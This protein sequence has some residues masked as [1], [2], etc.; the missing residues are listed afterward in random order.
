[1][2][3]PLSNIGLLTWLAPLAALGLLVACG[4][5]SPSQTLPSDTAPA[6]AVLPAPVAAAP[7]GQVPVAAEAATRQDANIIKKPPAALISTGVPQPE[8]APS[9]IGAIPAATLVQPEP[10]VQ[11]VPPVESA[12][13]PLPLDAPRVEPAQEPAALTPIEIKPDPWPMPTSTLPAESTQ[14]LRPSTDTAASDPAQWPTSSTPVETRLPPSPAP[15]A[16][17]TQEPATSPPAAPSAVPSSM[18][19]N[20]QTESAPIDES[21]EQAPSFTLPTVGGGTTSLD[22]YLGQRNVVLVFYRAFW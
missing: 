17:P 1:M 10:S 20:P 6:K 15:A 8:S 3:R 7:A 2:K 5:G 12:G 9:A 16:T 18:S 11:S 22:S 14:S 4:P 19:D 21:L 13:L